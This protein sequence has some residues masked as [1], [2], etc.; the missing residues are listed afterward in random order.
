MRILF[1]LLTSASIALAFSACRSAGGPASFCDTIC[2]KDSIKF[3]EEN[4]ELKPYVYI[5]A[6]NC[7]ADTVTWS[8]S[9]FGSNKKMGLAGLVGAQVK[10]N[11]TA[12]SCFIK[13]T[14]YAWLAFN[15][16]SNGRGYVLKFPFNNRDAID[17]KTSA[18]N[19]F[20]PKFAVQKGLIAYSDRGNIF[21]ED[22]ATGKQ[23][24]MT[25]GQR[26][27]IDYDAIHEFI[28]SVNI[29]PTKI[30]TRVKIGDE[31]KNMEK[32]IELK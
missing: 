8:Y 12:V 16:C 4:H 11:P 19:S 3:V 32:T 6:S 22:M 2:L 17:R 1:F 24:M 5:S 28:D 10:L 31:W 14:S 30:W 23:A 25:F 21:V 7:N 15:D 27:E 13:D 9:G 20:D 29:T 18:I 26:L